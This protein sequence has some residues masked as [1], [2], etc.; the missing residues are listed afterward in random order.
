MSTQTNLDLTFGTDVR[1]DYALFIDTKHFLS[2][3]EVDD[4]VK[5]ISINRG[6]ATFFRV[7]HE[8]EQSSHGWL[9]NG[10]IIQWG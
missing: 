10:E 5:Q 3:W 4:V 2:D 7:I 6:E 8:G 9:E 1:G